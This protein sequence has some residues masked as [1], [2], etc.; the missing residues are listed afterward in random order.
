VYLS[1][2][3]SLK[4]QK[5]VFQGCDN[6]SWVVSKS[7][8]P[9]QM[10]ES[11]FSK[12]TYD[13]TP[14]YVHKNALVAYKTDITWS[15]FKRII[16]LTDEELQQRYD[17]MTEVKDNNQSGNVEHGDEESCE[18]EEKYDGGEPLTQAQMTNDHLF[19]RQE[20]EADDMV[21]LKGGNST[22]VEVWLDDDEIYTNKKLQDL[23]SVART[24]EGDFYNEVTYSAVSFEL[25]LPMNVELD[26]E[27]LIKGDRMPLDMYLNVGPVVGTKEI[28][29]K[30]YKIHKVSVIKPSIEGGHFS[31]QTISDYRKNGALRKNDG[32]L[33][34][35]WLTNTD[36]NVA[37]PGNDD[38][39]IANVEFVINE[40]YLMGWPK[41]DS[42]YFYANGF[43]NHQGK[44][45]GICCLYH[46]VKLNYK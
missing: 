40:T 11:N 27:Q 22:F 1:S 5:S 2:D 24:G 12:A 21:T 29:G 39:I 17:S 3:C 32:Y 44:T 31:A 6:I 25:Y 19:V 30:T 8:T 16:G 7:M 33:L 4:F 37:K 41:K 13:K 34:G 23:V 10:Y 38:F 26:I 15:N 46:R 14:L 43:A 9:P 28:K 18:Y 42:R 45:G 20:G 36:S 35:L